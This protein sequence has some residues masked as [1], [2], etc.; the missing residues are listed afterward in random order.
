MLAATRRHDPLPQARFVSV[1][2]LGVTPACAHDRPAAVVIDGRHVSRRRSHA[3]AILVLASLVWLL[4]VL[5]LGAWPWTR[6][7]AAGVLSYTFEGW[8]QWPLA[9][10]GFLGQYEPTDFARGRGYASY[11]FGFLFAMYALVSPLHHLF[12]LPFTLAHNAL[13]YLHVAA[14]LAVFGGVTRTELAGLVAR[15]GALGIGCVFLVVGL[16]VTTP[17][18]WSAMLLFNRDNLHVLVA[19]IFC[20]LSLDLFRESRHEGRFLAAGIVIGLYAPMYF[21]A[22]FLGR[23]CLDARGAVDRRFLAHGLGVG[24]LSLVSVALPHLVGRLVEVQPVSS[25]VLFRS[26]LDGS[27]AWLHDIIQAVFWP[28]PA[29]YQPY[30]RTSLAVHLGAV[31]LAVALLPAGGEARSGAGARTTVRRRMLAQAAFLAIPY[32][33]MAILLPQHTA[34]HPYFIDGLLLIA[35]SFLLGFWSLQEELWPPASGWRLCFWTL[36]VGFVLMTDLLHLAQVL[37]ARP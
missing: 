5:K 12:G 37:R 17:A 18:V 21:P 29:V 13:P 22:W 19:I 31:A 23:L 11:T 26:G 28:P 30:Q 33:T 1:N 32:L 24:V 14:L 36:G 7:P 8:Q 34:I 15:M 10:H 3:I 35:S 25:G 6:S 16:L 4:V 20:W 27:R 9:H 2:I